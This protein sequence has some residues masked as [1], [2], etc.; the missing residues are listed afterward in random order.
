MELWYL[1]ADTFVTP[2]YHD[3]DGKFIKIFGRGTINKEEITKTWSW[4][5][6][7]LYTIRARESHWLKNSRFPLIFLNFQKHNAAVQSAGENFVES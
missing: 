4:F 7:N 3:F 1:P 6:F 2:H 5:D